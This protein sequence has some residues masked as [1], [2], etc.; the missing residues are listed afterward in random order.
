MG[1]S[2]NAVVAIERG[3]SVPSVL[4]AMA[5]ANALNMTVENLFEPL[6]GNN[7]GQKDSQHG[8]VSTRI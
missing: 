7:D 4:M 5:L 6:G 2:R 1:A 3:E 8:G